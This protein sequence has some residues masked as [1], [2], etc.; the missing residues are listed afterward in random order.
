MV[1]TGTD[2]TSVVDLVTSNDTEFRL[3]I[4]QVAPLDHDNALAF[5]QKLNTYVS[6][7]L[8][9]Q[10]RKDY[11]DAADKRVIVRID[12]H[13]AATSFGEE[14]LRASAKAVAEYGI[15]WE[16]ADASAPPN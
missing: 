6:Y 4:V 14:L 9:G 13:A 15:G 1:R 11:P 7:A 3:V 10:L 12:L 8:D 5:Q 16:T 2:N